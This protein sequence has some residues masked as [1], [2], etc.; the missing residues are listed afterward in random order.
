MTPP[1]PAAGWDAQKAAQ[2]MWDAAPALGSPSVWIAFYAKHLS[3]ARPTAPSAEA[4][5]EALDNIANGR[6][7]TNFVM[8]TP[9]DWHN[10][11]TQMQTIARTALE[12][13]AP[14]QPAGETGDDHS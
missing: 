13:V 11:F 5:R 7:N 14:A 1:A 3:L 2:A 12:A 10:A 6:I 4:M 8:S 9:P